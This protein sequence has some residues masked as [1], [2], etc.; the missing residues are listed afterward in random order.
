[1]QYGEHDEGAVEQSYIVTEK[2]MIIL[3]GL[4]SASINDNFE[5]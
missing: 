2:V 5:N 3:N 4:R 1:M